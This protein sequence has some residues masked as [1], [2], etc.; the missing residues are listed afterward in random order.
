MQAAPK[1]HNHPNQLTEKLELLDQGEVIQQKYGCE[2]LA[3]YNLWL[4][5]T[6]AVVEATLNPP[7]SSPKKI[8]EI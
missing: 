1:D 7:P 2:P 3:K 4:V 5:M 8:G 6:G